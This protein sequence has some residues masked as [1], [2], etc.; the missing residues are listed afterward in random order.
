LITKG[1]Y[2]GNY[3]LRIREGDHPYW[4]GYIE[5]V[6]GG[7]GNPD[8]VFSSHP[9]PPGEYVQIAVT[10]GSDGGHAY[11]DGS[12]ANWWSGM[13]EHPPLLNND[14]VTIGAGG[15][16]SMSNLYL[17]DID[18]VCIYNRVLTPAEIAAVGD[19]T[20]GTVPTP[21]A[22]LLG[23]VGAGLVGW[24]RRRRTL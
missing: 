9:I 7:N 3:T 23:T 16:Y 22:I 19:D 12:L 24:L 11:L 4:P 2:C 15:F 17:G 5:Y 1:L 20:C 6:H 14:P 13:A 18:Y 10:Y 8:L 21:A